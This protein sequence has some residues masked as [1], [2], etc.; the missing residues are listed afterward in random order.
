M[1]QSTDLHNTEFYKAH[2]FKSVA[3]VV[4]GDQ[5]PAWHDVPVTIEIASEPKND[6]CISLTLR[7][8]MIREPGGR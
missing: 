6:Y 4:L 3:D 1:V 8:K 2:G 7:S 5:N